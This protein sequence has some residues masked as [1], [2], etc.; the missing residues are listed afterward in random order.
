M[1]GRLVDIVVAGWLLVIVAIEIDGRLLGG[2]L[3]ARQPLAA[4]TPDR[5]RLAVIAAVIVFGTEVFP[6]AYWGRTPGKAML[7]LRCVDI[8]TG[9]PPGLVRS[10]F[11]G[12]LLH[13]WVAI[14][15]LGWVLPLAITV[16]TV[17]GSRGRGVHDRLAGTMVIDAVPEDDLLPGDPRLDLL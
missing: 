14:P 12:M 3:L 9:R 6:T 4:V 11:R 15:V 10:V 16:T 17:G 13:A 2:D 1:G 8:D 7:G 5:T